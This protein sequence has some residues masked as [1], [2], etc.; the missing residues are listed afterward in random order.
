MVN[1]QRLTRVACSLTGLIVPRTPPMTASSVPTASKRICFREYQRGTPI[2]PGAPRGCAQ[3]GSLV[4]AAAE[5]TAGDACGYAEAE[6][7][8]AAPSGER[9]PQGDAPAPRAC[10]PV[11]AGRG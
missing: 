7:L 2:A 6:A 1:V 11:L 9:D 8:R 10:R 5:D 4:P 3:S